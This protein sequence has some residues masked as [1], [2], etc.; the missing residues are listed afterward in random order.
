VRESD[1]PRSRSYG[2]TKRLSHMERSNE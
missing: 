2:S 1:D